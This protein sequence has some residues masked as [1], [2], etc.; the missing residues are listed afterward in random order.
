MNAYK[1]ILIAVDLSDDSQKVCQKALEVTQGENIH[2]FLLHVVEFIYQMGTSYDPMF[3]P[4]LDDLSENEEQLIKLSKEK[5]AQLINEMNIPTSITLESSV[6]S[7]IPKTEILNLAE[8]KK[9][10]LIVCGSHGRSGFELLLGSTAN[11]ILH[12]APCDVLAV[13]TKKSKE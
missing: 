3:Y 2:I 1:Q 9:V 12:H 10:D 6:L 11:A 5:M 8:E 4:S 7:G 13:R